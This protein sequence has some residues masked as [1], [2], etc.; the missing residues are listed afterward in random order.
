M[1]EI[2]KPVL[3]ITIK[4]PTASGKSTIAAVIAE[5]LRNLGFK[6]E[7]NYGEQFIPTATLIKPL[8]PTHRQIAQQ[9]LAAGETDENKS[10]T[11]RITEITE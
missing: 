10:R 3:D 5:A 9:M 6:I 11:V 1:K 8:G 4:G 2:S 7:V